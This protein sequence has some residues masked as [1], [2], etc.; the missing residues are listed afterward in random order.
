MKRMREIIR[1]YV[2]VWVIFS[3]VLLAA[4]L[5]LFLF[6]SIFPTFADLLNSTVSAAL[7]FIFATVSGIF[8]FS[9]FEMC[10]ILA[11]ALAV[12]LI[13][14]L[15]RTKRGRVWRVRAVSCLVGV[16]FILYSLYA[17]ML[18]I[19]YK[20]SPL[21]EKMDL[22]PNP[23]VSGEELY[24]LTEY[25]V[26]EINALAPNIDFTDGETRMG[27]SLDELSSKLSLAYETLE[28]KYS[29]IDSS[30]TRIKPVALSSVM[31]DMGIM[32]IYGYFT[33]EANINISYPDYTVPFTAAH[34]MAHQRGVA[35]ENEANFIAY[36]VC[37]ESDDEYIRYSGYL[38]LFEYL[39]SALYY[40][41][42]AG[43]ET[44]VSSLADCVVSDIRASNAITR[45]H[46]DSFINKFM[47]KVNDLYLKS[48]GTEGS[49]SYS[50]VTRLALS[51]YK[52]R[53][54]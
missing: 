5:I 39:A 3:A 48:N 38:G 17:L 33:G 37:I 50:Y 27:Y 24:R 31:S 54:N 53:I 15:V 13:V 2:P 22:D 11:P 25:I 4:S 43:Y 46:Q 18:G 36:L 41:D 30:F 29:F 34:E 10:L 45:E 26:D 9:L 19:G 7:R 1:K 28:Q 51:Y 23:E 44:L 32:G 14:A 47:D 35:R 6:A 20:T 16:I 8:P 49:I 52:D 40:T 42:K 12:I 21:S